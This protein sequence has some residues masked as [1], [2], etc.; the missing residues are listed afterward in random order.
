[1]K[2]FSAIAYF[3]ARRLQ[4]EL[5]IPIGLID[6]AWGGSPAEVWAGVSVFDEN[7][8]LAADANALDPSKWGLVGPSRIYN[9]MVHPITLLKLPE[10]F[11]TKV[12]RT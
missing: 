1:M 12:S 8:V 3:F 4:G 11:G 9:A 7:P 2:D 6:N 5:N 10:L